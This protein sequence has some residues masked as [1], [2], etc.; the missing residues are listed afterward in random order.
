MSD[1][2]VVLMSAISYRQREILHIQNFTLSQIP[3]A[4]PLG[5][6]PNGPTDQS[7]PGSSKTV[8]VRLVTSQKS[9]W[10]ERGDMKMEFSIL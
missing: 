7:A 2:P 5:I 4:G 6:R 1:T 10:Q 8:H 3:A 9:A